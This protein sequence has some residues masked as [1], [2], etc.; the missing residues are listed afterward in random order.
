MLPCERNT[1]EIGWS[2]QTG[3]ALMHGKNG[4]LLVPAHLKNSYTLQSSRTL[5]NINEI[6]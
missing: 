5:M 4:G 6:N 3:G 2:V 1:T